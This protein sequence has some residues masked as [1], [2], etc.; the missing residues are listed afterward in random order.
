[1]ATR[2]GCANSRKHS[3][4]KRLVF[5]CGKLI[6]HYPVAGWLRVAFS[7]MKRCAADSKWDDPIAK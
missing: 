1:M 7:Y 2:L 6:G 4:K 3:Y 5:V